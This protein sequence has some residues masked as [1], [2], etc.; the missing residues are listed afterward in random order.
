LTPANRLRSSADV[1]RVLRAGR[2]VSSGRAVS[3]RGHVLYHSPRT[4]S[5]RSRFG[6]VVS[7]RVGPAVVRNRVKRLL[8]EAVRPLLPVLVIPVDAVIVAREP[9]RQMTL[10]D[11]RRALTTTITEAGRTP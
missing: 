1:Q 5:D 7:R 6:F 10:D 9:M 2:A 4:G 3:G 11:V 8:R